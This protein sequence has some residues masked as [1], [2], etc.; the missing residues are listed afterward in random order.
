MAYHYSKHVKIPFD[1][2][3]EELSDQLTDQGFGILTKIDIQK[4]FK[5]KLG[6]D[7]RRYTI[8]GVCNPKFAF[9]VI[10]FAPQIGVMLPCNV[11]IQ[12]HTDGK[13]EIS[14]INPAETMY[15]V[16]NPDLEKIAAQV[17]KKLRNAIDAVR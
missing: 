16:K 15:V 1:A 8:L 5:D 4:T 7:F 14:A 13:V 3:L 10:S 2:V 9:E 17:S 11:A 6:I 12:E